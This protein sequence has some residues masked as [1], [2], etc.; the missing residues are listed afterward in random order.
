MRFTAQNT[1]PIPPSGTL[2]CSTDNLNTSNPNTIAISNSDLHG[3]DVN[4]IYNWDKIQITDV[5]NT[6]IYQCTVLNA[7]DY[8]SYLTLQLSFNNIIGTPQA[9]DGLTIQFELLNLPTGMSVYWADILDKP[10]SYPASPH[11]IESHSDFVSSGAESNGQILTYES[12]NWTNLNPTGEA[13]TCSNV[14][15]AGVGVYKIKWVLILNS[16]IS[17]WVTN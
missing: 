10:S 13:N 17:M 4:N 9:I 15:T 7:V 6:V 1:T 11:T 8:P 16:R 12:G 2:Y 5:A 14:G 3:N